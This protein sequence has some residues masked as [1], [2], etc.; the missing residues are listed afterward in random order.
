MTDIFKRPSKQEIDSV[1]TLLKPWEWLTSP[2]F[3]GVENIPL[4]GPVLFVG[5]HTIIG[6]LDVPLMWMH[7]YHELGIYMRPL[8]DHFHFKVPIWRDILAKFGLVDGTRSN[9][10]KLVEH[11][12]YILVFPGGARE[13]AKRRGEEYQLIWQERLGFARMAIQHGCTIVPFASVGAE[14]CWDI[15]A[16]PDEIMQ[17]ALGKYLKKWGIRNDLIFPLVKGVGFTPLP[18]PQRF[19]FKFGKPI[20]TTQY[21]GKFENIRYCKDLREYTKTVVES[22]IQDLREYRRKDPDKALIPRL[23]HHFTHPSQRHSEDFGKEKVSM[24]DEIG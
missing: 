9:F 8:G 22:L 24:T 21:K 23:W 7:L 13:V 12:E 15:I 18:R 16:D 19:Y 20:D 5:N 4:E 11:G 14:E 6:I 1:A 3:F 10:S 17:S 2:A